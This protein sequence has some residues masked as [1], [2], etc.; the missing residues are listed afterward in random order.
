MYNGWR[1][2]W[3]VLYWDDLTDASV[4]GCWVSTGTFAVAFGKGWCWRWF[5]TTR[6]DW[7]PTGPWSFPWE[8]VSTCSSA[9]WRSL[10][11][12]EPACHH[13]WTWASWFG[14]RWTLFSW[15][16]VTAPPLPTS[17]GLQ[18]HWYSSAPVPVLLSTTQF[19]CSDSPPSL[20][21]TRSTPC[22]IFLALVACGL[23]DTSDF[24]TH[25]SNCCHPLCF[26]L[27]LALLLL[28][29]TFL[30]TI[31]SFGIT[32]P[33]INYSHIPTYLTTLSLSCQ[34]TVS[35]SYYYT[36]TTTYHQSLYSLLACFLSICSYYFLHLSYFS[37]QW[38]FVVKC[39]WK[40]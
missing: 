30:S 33:F 10:H 15:R 20:A 23:S 32:L 18:T 19:D 21:T 36:I 16:A 24:P 2:S 13:L 25:Y 31:A 34:M 6:S 40:Y 37:W 26:H 4:A 29:S 8:C 39:S 22:S 7:C 17:T 5:E 14:F 38:L 1:W 35:Y 28:L 9:C 3:W 12:S 27:S 11:P